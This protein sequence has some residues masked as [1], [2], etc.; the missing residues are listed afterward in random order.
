VDWL[1]ANN[2]ISKT[3]LDFVITQ[4]QENAKNF[5]YKIFEVGSIQ[6]NHFDDCIGMQYVFIASI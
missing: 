1:N 3:C 4:H 2:R 6:I 5:K